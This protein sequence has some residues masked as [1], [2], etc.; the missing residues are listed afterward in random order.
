[1]YQATSF[2]KASHEAEN[3][4]LSTVYGLYV[5]YIEIENSFIQ[6]HMRKKENVMKGVMNKRPHLDIPRLP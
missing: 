1:M 5:C 2:G 6:V 4:L 3:H